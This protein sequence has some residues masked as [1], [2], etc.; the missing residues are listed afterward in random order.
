MKKT[1]VLPQPFKMEV[2]PGF[3]TYMEL[4]EAS[5]IMVEYNL[6]PG[7]LG[8]TPKQFNYNLNRPTK[9]TTEQV[10]KIAEVVHGSRD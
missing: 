5:F 9:L 4:L 3:A 8:F 10:Y 7:K 1:R 6:L 2:K